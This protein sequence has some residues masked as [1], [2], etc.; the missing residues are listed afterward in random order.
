MWTY[1]EQL[2]AM[3]MQTNPPP[4]L[5]PAHGELHRMYIKKMR[6]PKKPKENPDD[7]T[8]ES[9]LDEVADDDE[10]EYEDEDVRLLIIFKCIFYF[11]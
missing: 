8:E 9:D 7:E 1:S 10:E 5:N 11:M 4:D 2:F 6:R 3:W